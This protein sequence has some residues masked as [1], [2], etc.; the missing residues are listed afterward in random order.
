MTNELEIY[1]PKKREDIININDII[2]QIDDLDNIV[3]SFDTLE[4]VKESK[5]L[6]TQANKYI[7]DFKEICDP[8]ETEGRQIANNRST[9]KLK[10]EKIVA[11]K[12]EPIL[13]RE[14]KLKSLKDNLFIPSLNIDSVKNKIEALKSLSGYEWFAYKEEAERIISQSQTYLD[15]ELV[16]FEEEAKKRIKDEEEARIKREDLIREE[17]KE[18]AIQDANRRVEQIKIDLE[19]KAKAKE[20]E[21]LRLEAAERVIIEAKEKDVE[22][23]RRIH[24]E[25]QSDLVQVIGDYEQDAI[26]REAKE[27]IKAIVTGKIRNLKIV[28]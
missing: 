18:K 12:L 20:N 24:R 6:K 22:N 11:S 15:G 21:R 27:I 28:Y 9:V 3:L 2:D 1:L 14:S 13:E 10:L 23:K 25:I 17:E 19:N 4:D 7:K 5:K 26:E 8:F 16:K